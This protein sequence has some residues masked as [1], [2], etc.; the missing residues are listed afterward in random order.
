M[1]AGNWAEALVGTSVLA[2]A[3]ARVECIH[4]ITQ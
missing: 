2:V 3:R 1:Q 4:T